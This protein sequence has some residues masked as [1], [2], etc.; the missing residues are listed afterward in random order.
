MRNP[1]EP[2]LKQIRVAIAEICSIAHH[3]NGCAGESKRCCSS[4][5]VTVNR[6]E[7]QNI[8]GCIKMASRFCPG[9]L[10][11]EGYENVFD[12]I[13]RNLFSIDTNDDGVCVFAYDKDTMLLCSLHSA[14]QKTGI[15]FKEV[16]PLSCLLWPLTLS[17]G[18]IPVLS[19]QDDA[20][21]F[22]CNTRTCCT[23]FA[24]SPSIALNIEWAFGS[25]FKAKVLE[26]VER[27]VPWITIPVDV[28]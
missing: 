8:D 7:R 14:A 27:S 19:L 23:S 11:D 12:P 10:S 13:S 1:D 17:E 25:A 16:K 2:K 18:S 21:E 9:L 5:E 20:F 22:T 6:T 3:C 28:S 15:S 4:Y 24:L 26:A